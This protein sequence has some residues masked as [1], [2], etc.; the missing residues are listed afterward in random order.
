MQRAERKEN[1]NDQYYFCCS[2]FQIVIN[3]SI[4]DVIDYSEAKKCERISSR[5]PRNMT[6]CAHFL[7]F[8][9][10][11]MLYALSALYFLTISR[12]TVKISACNTSSL[13]NIRI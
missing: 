5:F 4:G 12:S 8:S 13:D 3:D 2:F 9:Y 1:P 7:R 11:Y 10:G 6:E